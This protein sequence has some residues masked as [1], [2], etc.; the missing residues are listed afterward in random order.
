MVG[1]LV[2]CFGF[3]L[4]LLTQASE[5]SFAQQKKDIQGIYARDAHRL[6]MEARQGSSMALSR[7]RRRSKAA[8]DELRHPVR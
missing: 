8:S 4:G 6:A 7:L 1:R 3:A 5:R 2:L